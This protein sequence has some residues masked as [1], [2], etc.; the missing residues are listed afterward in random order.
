MKLNLKNKIA[1]VTGSTHGIGLS[2]AKTLAGEGCI[3]VLNGRKK[4]ARP[5]INLKEIRNTIFFP[6]DV[7][8]KQDCDRLIKNIIK[9]FGKLDILVCN[10][11]SGKSVPPGKETNSD[12]EDMFLKNLFS[13]TNII[14]S[15]E[16]ALEKTKGNIV[17]ISSIAG[18]E[19]TG[20]PIPYSVAKAALNSYVKNISKEFSK[21]KIRI[22][23]VAPGNILFEGSTWDDKIKKNNLKVK[24][25]LKEKVAMNRF[26]RPDEVAGM[27]TFLVSSQASFITGSVFVV[28]GG[29]VN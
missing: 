9:K 6:A 3:V 17:C 12:C 10:V 23:S 1:L 19:V 28:D 7:T 4:P 27:V 8:K 15:S 11:G 18:I 5:K 21:K 14:K 25:M 22:N 29:Q 13:A 24:K 20:G 26:G 2:I 16:K